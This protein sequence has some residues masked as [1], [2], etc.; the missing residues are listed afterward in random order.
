MFSLG[1]VVVVVLAI[2]LLVAAALL[3]RSE[4][5]SAWPAIVVAAV[6]SG[7]CFTVGGDSARGPSGPSIATVVGAVAG[8]VTVAAAALALVPRTRP[9]FTRLP[10]LVA[11]AAIVIGAAGL[12]LNELIG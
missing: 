8:I 7:I 12:L 10:T 2:L 3:V 1:A 11:T 4:H 5:L 6:A 9:P